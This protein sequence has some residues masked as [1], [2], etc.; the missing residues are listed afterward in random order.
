MKPFKESKLG[1]WLKEKAPKVLD[2][3]GDVLP[4]GGVLGIVKNLIDNNED[5]TPEQKLE[6]EKLHKEHE[7]EIMAL[8]VRDRE[9]ARLMKPDWMM[10]AVGLWV[11]LMTTWVVYAVFYTE[12]IASEMSHLIAGEIIGFAASVVM[13]YFGASYSRRTK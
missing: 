7:A 2:T 12:V 1:Q 11:L 4:S 5:L 13:L 9:S 3:I 10:R 8:E 6:F